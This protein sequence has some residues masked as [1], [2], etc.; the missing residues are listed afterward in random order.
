MENVCYDFALFT[1]GPVTGMELSTI[2]GLAH[3]G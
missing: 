3:A 1:Q 2:L